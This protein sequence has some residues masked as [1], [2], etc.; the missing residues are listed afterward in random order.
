MRLGRFEMEAVGASDENIYIQ[1]ATWNGQP[2]DRT[3]ITHDMISRGGR[4]VLTMGAQ[5]NRQWGC[6]PD[7][8]P[9][10]VR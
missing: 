7:A 6:G 8:V 5:P 4:L 10:T 9:A 2:Y 1:S 3:Y